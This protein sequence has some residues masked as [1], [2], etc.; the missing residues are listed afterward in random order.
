[1]V[2]G[3][4]E[5]MPTDEDIEA[6]VELG[7]RVSPWLIRESASTSTRRIAASSRALKVFGTEAIPYAIDALKSDS[8]SVRSRAAWVVI[9]VEKERSYLTLKSLSGDPSERVRVAVVESIRLSGDPRLRD[10]LS[11][12]LKDESHLVRE[13]AGC[14]MRAFLRANTPV[15]PKT[16]VVEDKKGAAPERKD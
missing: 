4:L 8:A 3:S 16:P 11:R 7:P 15:P 10:E 6:I 1:M 9:G 14:A 13:E 5:E 12:F 2:M